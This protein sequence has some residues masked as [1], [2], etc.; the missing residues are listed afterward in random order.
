MRTRGAAETIS[1]ETAV[2][3]KRLEVAAS[4]W[5]SRFSA[6]APT[7]RLNEQGITQ[8]CAQPVSGECAKRR[9]MG[10]DVKEIGI[11]TLLG[12]AVTAAAPG[13]QA[14]RP[15]VYA[16]PKTTQ[17]FAECFAQSQHR[18]GKAWWFVPREH[19][20]TFSD[21]GA[22]AVAKPYFLV[23]NDRGKRREIQLERAPYGELKE[24]VS[25]CL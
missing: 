8:P 1:T 5:G 9:L 19:G 16:T 24:A 3:F 6:V 20:G 11:V 15:A 7:A 13:P 14:Y 18:S 17:D 4:F 2:P 10:V 22:K 25:Q 12:V 21:A 23:I